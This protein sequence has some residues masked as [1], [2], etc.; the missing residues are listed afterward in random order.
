[1]ITIAESLCDLVV[2]LPLNTD[3]FTRNIKSVNKQIQEAESYFKLAS[4]RIKDFDTSTDA[5]RIHLFHIQ[6]SAGRRMADAGDR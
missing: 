1:M 6:Q 3:N 5:A 4:A 2:S